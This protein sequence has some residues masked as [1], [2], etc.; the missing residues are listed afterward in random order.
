MKKNYGIPNGV[1]LDDS[2]Y[3]GF[4]P[5]GIDDCHVAFHC[6]KKNVVG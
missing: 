3:V 5:D 2:S 6:G 1:I 4:V